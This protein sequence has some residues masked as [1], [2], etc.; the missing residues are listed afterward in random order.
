MAIDKKID[1]RLNT[2]EATLRVMGDEV[3]ILKFSQDLLC[4]ASFQHICVIATPYNKSQFPRASNKVHVMG[5]WENNNDS[6]NLQL[7]RQQI[8]AMQRAHDQVISPVDVAKMISEDLQ[9]FNL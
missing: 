3:Q 6:L 4:H 9:G 5:A 2:L 7:L 1:I 8:L